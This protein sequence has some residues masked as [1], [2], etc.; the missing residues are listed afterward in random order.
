MVKR[1]SIEWH[2]PARVGDEVDCDCSVVRW[3]T[4]SFDVE[5]IGKVGDRDV[6][7]AHLVQVSTVPGE[8]RSTPIPEA[9]RVA[10]S[11]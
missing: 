2:T 6:F 9:V 4:S 11:R 5:V 10:L 7:T 3:G 1:A 8:A